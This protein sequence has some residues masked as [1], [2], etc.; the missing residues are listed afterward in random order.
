MDIE[1]DKGEAKV[2][3]ASLVQQVNREDVAN[4]VQVQRG[5]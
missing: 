4:M 1:A 5:M 3:A 2:L